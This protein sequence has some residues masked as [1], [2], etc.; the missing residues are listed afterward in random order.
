MTDLKLVIFDVDGTLVDSQGDILGAMSAAFAGEGL[1]APDRP[2]VLRIVG[3]SLPQAMEQL[4]PDLGTVQRTRMVETYKAAY[5]AQVTCTASPLYDGIPE[6]LDRLGDID[7]LLLGVATGKSRRGLSRLLKAHG[8]TGRFVTT[9][10]A[11]DHPSK[12]H[13]AMLF[14]ALDE[15]GLDAAQAVMIGDTS[16]DMDM[17]EAAGIRGIGVTWGYHPADALGAAVR[18]VNDTQELAGA[19]GDM[20]EV[21]I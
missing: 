17:A 12:P 7:D 9:Q 20:L 15:L 6:L 21:T 18:V 3:L 4:V 14:S 13:P 8:L 2:D 1:V 5:A 10:V 16:Y 11:D 19:I